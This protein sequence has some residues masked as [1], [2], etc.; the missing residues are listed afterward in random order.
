MKLSTIAR[1]GVLAA[2]IG[3]LLAGAADARN[4]HCAGGIQYVTQA[5]KDKDK[6]NLEDYKREINKAVQQLELCSKED[7][8]DFEGAGY[9]GWAYAEVDSM[10]K[11]GAA[12]ETAVQGLKKKGDVK[13]A[14]QWVNNRQAFWVQ[15]Y[16]N[17]ISKI[18]DAQAMYPDFC[19]EASDAEK[20]TRAEAEKNYQLAIAS[21][22][23]ALALKPGD[24]QT[25]RTI[26]KV[27]ATTCDYTRA[28]QALREGLKAAPGDTAMTEM[29]KG[30][31]MN[32]C[33]LLAN[34]KKYDEALAC[35]E[36][37]A[38]SDP[39][40][41]DVHSAMGDIRFNRAQALK[42]DA[43]KAEFAA[44]GAHYA[45]AFEI[46]P[47]DADLSFNAALS[48]QNAQMWDKA[49]ALWAKTA[50]IRPND[51]DVHSAWGLVLAELKRCSDAI[52]HAHKAVE[53]KAQDPNFHRQLGTTYTRCG[54][55]TKG[56]DELVVFL[57]MRD[58]K[59][60]TDVAAQAKS[61]RQG[62]E[63]AKTLA[64]DGVPEAIY[65][66]ETDGK[67]YETWFYWG[68]KRALAFSD[69]AL[70]RKSDWAAADTKTASGK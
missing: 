7:P 18:N 49:E 21:L 9:L 38:K 37:I 28:E 64:V 53:L 10:A 70:T 15:N 55:A 29:L 17:G 66:W 65:L 34:S 48:Y 52:S 19:K 22:N 58:G 6:G 36:G 5:M 47:T 50:Q 12:F 14:E 41:S 11:A 26:A 16:N 1:G 43:Q 13:K 61:A 23:K 30:V 32:N 35:Y 67:K 39:K 68:K 4:P 46:K 27:Y 63:A 25:M 57:A 44:G 59:P 40:N 2:L 45:K 69:G 62:T 31:T 51:P 24:A 20:S 8:A 56:T 42:A 3:T 33:A 54:N 60:V